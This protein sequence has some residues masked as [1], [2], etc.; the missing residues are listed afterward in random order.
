MLIAIL[1]LMILSCCP[2]DIDKQ[3]ERGKNYFVSIFSIIATVLF[4]VY[5]TSL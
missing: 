3:V 1:I 5:M 4:I 2:I